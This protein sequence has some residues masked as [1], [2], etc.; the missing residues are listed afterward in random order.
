VLWGNND[1][2]EE[3]RRQQSTNRGVIPS[4]GSAQNL[5]KCSGFSELQPFLFLFQNDLLI[6][7]V[8]DPGSAKRYPVSGTVTPQTPYVTERLLVFTFLPTSSGSRSPA[9]S[10]LYGREMEILPVFLSY[11][12][13]VTSQIVS[14]K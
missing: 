12:Y 14:L 11:C 5:F 8:R 7:G 3:W 2:V 13:P 6:K 4:I 1:V 10:I 9:E